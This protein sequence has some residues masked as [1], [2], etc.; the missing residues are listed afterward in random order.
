MPGAKG[1]PG[2]FGQQADSVH[3][4]R[5]RQNAWATTAGTFKLKNLHMTVKFGE[6][7]CF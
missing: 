3:I 7:E 5:L 2:L 4:E 6:N 1:Q